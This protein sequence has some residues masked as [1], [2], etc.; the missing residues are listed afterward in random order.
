ML[1]RLMPLESGSQ[2]AMKSHVIVA[3]NAVLDIRWTRGLIRVS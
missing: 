3:G 1:A 2:P